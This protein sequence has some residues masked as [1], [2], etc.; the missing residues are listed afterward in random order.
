MTCPMLVAAVF[1]SMEGRASWLAV[2]WGPPGW[3]YG[4]V[5]VALPVVQMGLV[6]LAGST[7][8]WIEFNPSHIITRTPTD[9]LALNLV[10]AVPGM[11]IPFLLLSPGTLLGGWVS[12]LGEE[13]AWRGYLFGTLHRRGSA[14]LPAAFATG[15][16]WWLWHLPFLFLSPV[17]TSLP[18]GRFLLL[19]ASSFPA[20][21][22]TSAIYC[23][24]Y[25]VS[26]S[27]WAPTLMHLFWNLYRGILTGR[28]S[29]G[30]PGLF[31]G[32]LWL[33]NGEGVLGNLVSTAF[34]ILFL[35]L[36]ARRDRRTATSES[37]SSHG[38]RE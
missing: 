20:L 11:V 33:I 23:W 29:D 3:L 4:A 21:V 36:L 13:V 19:L 14:L 9:H 7:G 35:V 1:L 15:V 26:G 8:G 27:I 10:L 32:P 2:G 37:G 38:Q 16:I 31:A 24:M 25:I 6:L 17:L 5:S 22:G 34:G 28:L 30:A 18:R 12:H